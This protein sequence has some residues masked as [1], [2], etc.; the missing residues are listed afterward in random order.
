VPLS[1]SDAN[2]TVTEYF[3]ALET[4]FSHFSGIELRG[5]DAGCLESLAVVTGTSHLKTL[6][7]ATLPTHWQGA[8]RYQVFKFEPSELLFKP[9]VQRYGDTA[10]AIP[11][12]LR[13]ADVGWQSGL[14]LGGAFHRRGEGWQYTGTPSTAG[15]VLAKAVGVRLSA[16]STLVIKGALKSGGLDFALQEGSKMVTTTAVELKGRFAVE[17]TVPRSGSYEVV[18][19]APSPGHI[20]VSITKTGI[21]A[22]G[23]P[24]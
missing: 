16:G 19:T 2:P 20:G 5:N 22:P 9:G 17:L 13:S 12:N 21:V 15:S 23:R 8:R 7:D 6:L 24:G 3:V 1:F 11:P 18:G 10:V 14:G 4:P